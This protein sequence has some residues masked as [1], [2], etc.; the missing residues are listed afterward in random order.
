MGKGVLKCTLAYTLA[1][2][3]TFLEPLSD[4][5]GKPDG[6]HVVATIT[7]YFHPAR[8]AG[9]MIEAI[10]IATVAVSYALIVSFLSMTVSVLVGSVWGQIIISH[11]LVVVIFIGGGFGF[12]GWVKQKMNNPLVNVGSTLASLAI[13]SVVTKEAAVMSNV[14]SNNK[15]IQILKM[16]VM[17]ITTTT[18][19]N[20]LLWRVSAVSLLRG[21][22]TR[23][24]TSLSDM[25]TSITRAFLSGSEEDVLTSDF[26]TASAAYSAIYPQ[27]TKSLREAKFE[28]YF[29]GREN[30]YQLERAV[31]KSMEALAQS[32]GGLR[33]AAN[34]QIA[35]L[36][37]SGISPD[38]SSGILSPGSTVFSPTLNR[39]LS[40][41]LKSGKDRN[42]VLSA[43][44]EASEESP[45]EDSARSRTRPV[46]EIPAFRSP[47]EIFELFIALL[48]PSMKS[49][50]YT[51]SEI[52]REP[53][54]GTAPDY[55]LT[56][57]EQFRH[58]LSDALGL[59]NT[60]RANALQELYVQ[61]EL[62]KSRAEKL[63]ADFEEV[64]ASCG[65]FS[66]SLQTFGEEMQKY[67]DVLDDLN[68]AI[69]NSSRSWN[70]LMWWKPKNRRRL[71]SLP[72]N[73]D[74]Q[75]SLIKP[76]KKTAM[77]RGIPDSMVERR[78]TYSWQ[79]EPTVNTMVAK[80]SQKLLKMLRKLAR[81][82]SKFAFPL[83]TC[84]VLILTG[85][86]KFASVSKLAW[87]RLYGPCSP[88]YQIH[89]TR[90]STGE[91]SGGSCRS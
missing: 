11:L 3:A 79:A 37:K 64:A 43:I 86:G 78:D 8:S 18:L 9:S 54:F 70:W 49:L 4:F 59:F 62:D 15:I 88:S 63:R 83:S 25:L 24:S 31:V 32:I 16:L 51:L 60:A 61:L 26:T 50:A 73:A 84:A 36:K 66:F 68:D 29:L 2:L 80:F 90:T 65:H 42:H 39:A 47:S 38:P 44:D 14:F 19:V 28:R 23:A 46:V 10:L 35:L 53:P 48:G 33:S 12:L 74:E 72:F 71:A 75:E 6:K 58:S 89:E 77:L 20:L 69:E 5:L 56:I 82:E 13:I 17:G 40:V 76:I 52:L 34:T 30:I 81:D 41:M 27:M 55:E 67:L 85:L 57:N 7:V 1:S 21:S 45:A 22:M 87:E 91:A